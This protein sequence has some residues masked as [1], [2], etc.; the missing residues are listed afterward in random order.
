[1]IHDWL[2]RAH[3]G[4]DG[5]FGL[6]EAESTIQRRVKDTEHDISLRLGHTMAVVVG[7]PAAPCV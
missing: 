3:L 5:T 6:E 2:T 1:M 7:Y 4:D